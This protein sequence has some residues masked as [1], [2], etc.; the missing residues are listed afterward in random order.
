MTKRAFRCDQCEALMINGVFCHEAGCPNSRAR[1]DKA[2]DRW[3]P[4]RKCREC[5]NMVDEGEECCAA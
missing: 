2:E 3:I 5:G 4:Q 1:Y